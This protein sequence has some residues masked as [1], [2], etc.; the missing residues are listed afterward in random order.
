[1]GAAGGALDHDAGAGGHQGGGAAV[2]VAGEDERGGAGEAL[3]DDVVVHGDDVGAFDLGAVLAAVP[4]HRGGVELDVG[5]LV[6][7]EAGVAEAVDVEACDV[8]HLVV[9]DD[10]VLLRGDG[11]LGGLGV[12]VSPY[13]DIGDTQGPDL[14]DELVLRLGAV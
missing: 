9:E 1:A 10:R 2:R 6:G 5:G 3:G 14:L 4:L 11:L 13:E 7:G 8:A 12:V